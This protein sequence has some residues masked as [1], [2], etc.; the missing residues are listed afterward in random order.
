MN[1]V[2]IKNLPAAPKAANPFI[3]AARGL[4]SSSFLKFSKG[5]WFSGAENTPIGKDEL[6]AVDVAGAEHGYVRFR[7]GNAPAVQMVTVASGQEVLREHLPAL[8]DVS[9]GNSWEEAYSVRLVR[10]SSGEEYTYC[11]TSRGGRDTIKKLLG[12]YGRRQEAGLPTAPIVKLGAGEYKHKKY[13][14]VPI[15]DLQV[16]EWHG[17]AAKADDDLRDDNDMGDEIPY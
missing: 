15:P 2:T 14:I 12:Q 3:E 6:F 8:D 4:R 11:P 5:L 9:D 1:L 10:L 7:E 16:A 17:S 13:G